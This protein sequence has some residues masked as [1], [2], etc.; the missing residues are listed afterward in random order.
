[1]IQTPIETDLCRDHCGAGTALGSG[2][3]RRDAQKAQGRVNQGPHA[4][5]STRGHRSFENPATATLWTCR[6]CSLKPKRHCARPA[7]RPLRKCLQKQGIGGPHAR[8][9]PVPAYVATRLEEGIRASADATSRGLSGTATPSHTPSGSPPPQ[10]STEI[11][12]ACPRW[13][14]RRHWERPPQQG[15]LHYCP[16]AAPCPNLTPA[17]RTA[18]PPLPAL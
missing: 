2:R 8:I 9:S 3:G 7:Y 6:T 11:G 18:T 12:D 4:P 17:C 1:M 16:A 14:G 15:C 10:G 5:G 13:K